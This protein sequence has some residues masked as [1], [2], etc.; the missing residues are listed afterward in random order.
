[1]ELNAS[2]GADQAEVKQYVEI[3]KDESDSRS[4]LR[5]S[6]MEERNARENQHRERMCDGQPPKLR[7]KGEPNGNNKGMEGC[8]NPGADI[9]RA[10]PPRHV[11]RVALGAEADVPKQTHHHTARL[12]FRTSGHAGFFVPNE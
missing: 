11:L 5:A 4:Q 6:T 1:M 3:E 8:G 9:N 2:A 12:L 10:K 7:E